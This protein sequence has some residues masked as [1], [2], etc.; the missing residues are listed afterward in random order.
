MFRGGAWLIWA[1]MWV[2]CSFR[3]LAAE[4]SDYACHDHAS[5]CFDNHAYPQSSAAVALHMRNLRKTQ[6]SRFPHISLTLHS[7][8]IPPSLPI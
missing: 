4:E 6:G 7:L 3:K 2:F 1:L 8:Y 5:C